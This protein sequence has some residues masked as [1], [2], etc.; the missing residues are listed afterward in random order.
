MTG[1][2]HKAFIVAGIRN[3]TN[4]GFVAVNAC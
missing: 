2:R 4:L 3:N 1:Y